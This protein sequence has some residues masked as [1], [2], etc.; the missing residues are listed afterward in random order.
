MMAAPTPPSEGRYTTPTG[1]PVQNASVASAVDVLLSLAGRTTPPKSPTPSS[2]A[3]DSCGRSAASHADF[4]LA[5]AAGIVTHVDEKNMRSEQPLKRESPTFTQCGVRNPPQMGVHCTTST[6]L[7][8]ATPISGTTWPPINMGPMGMMNP[9]LYVHPHA[10]CADMIRILGRQAVPPSVPKPATSTEKPTTS[11]GHI[12]LSVASSAGGPVDSTSTRS[13]SG[14]DGQAGN[15]AT[16]SSEYV[17][18]ATAARLN[19]SKK[20][21]DSSFPSEY[22]ELLDMSTTE[23]NRYLKVAQLNGHE[24][25]E[26]RK[27]R[28]RKKNRLYAKRSRGKK[29]QKLMDMNTKCDILQATV[30]HLTQAQMQAQMQSQMSSMHS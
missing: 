28:R 15:A 20:T 5:K 7:S 30:T 11:A 22:H 4:P 12:A 27:A 21:L 10:Q 14:I 23:F 25:S 8:S 3:S 16:P 18:L 9:M 29:L 19:Q 26:L 2:S 24:I 13:R 6:A 17:S 1:T